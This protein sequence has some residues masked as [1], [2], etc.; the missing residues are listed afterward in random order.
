MMYKVFQSTLDH[1][2]KKIKYLMEKK[3]LQGKNTQIKNIH[4][5]SLCIQEYLM[6]GNENSEIAKVII[7]VRGKNL[8]IKEHKK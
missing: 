4:Y 6:N 1:T 2:S 8:E 7:K 5:N 3:N